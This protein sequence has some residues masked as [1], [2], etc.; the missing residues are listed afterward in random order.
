MGLYLC[1]IFSFHFLLFHVS[2]KPLSVYSVGWFSLHC[3]IRRGQAIWPYSASADDRLLEMDF[4]A[5]VYE[6]TS[7]WQNIRIIRTRV[8]GNALFLDGEPS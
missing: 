5:L 3:P 2:W 4:E 7:P 1:E 6:K 8:S